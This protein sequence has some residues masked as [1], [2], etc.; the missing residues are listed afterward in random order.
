V[1]TFDR[2]IALD[3][4]DAWHWAITADPE[5]ES[6]N[7]IFGGWTAAVILHAVE[8]SDVHDARPS[9]LSVSFIDRVLPGSR[10]RVAVRPLGEGRYIHHWQAIVRP[11]DHQEP[12]AVASVVLTN[13]RASDGVT[14]A[15]KPEAPDPGE[16]PEFHAPGPQGQRVMIRPVT[17]IPPFN[18]SDTRSVA[19]VRDMDPRPL[20]YRQLA[21]LTDQRAPR[22]YYWSPGPRA[23]A[24]VFLSVFFHATDEELAQVGDDY[25]LSE[26][27]GVRGADSTS[28]EHHRLWSRDG[29]LLAT[30][31]QL[32]WYR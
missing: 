11:A 17:G 19:W 21:Y 24:T 9:V 16:L 30:S 12:L 1:T 14:T 3:Q 23:S 29:V 13:R 32:A 28:E 10:L 4:I 6:V 8:M 5:E 26:A 27:F 18:R 31:E 2:S 15:T 7:A 22:S 25:L 20:D